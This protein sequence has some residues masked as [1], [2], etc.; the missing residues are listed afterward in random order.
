MTPRRPARPARPAGAAHPVRA[1]RGPRV[2]GL[3]RARFRFG[4][5]PGVTAPPGPAGRA[6]GAAAARALAEAGLGHLGGHLDL[7]TYGPAPR[8][9][10]LAHAARRAVTA[11]L[12]ARPHD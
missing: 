3:V 8:G 5:L 2:G 10:R 4:E 12:A 1:A 7:R 6:A 9:P 11:A